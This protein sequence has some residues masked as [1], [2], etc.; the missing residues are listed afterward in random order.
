M[1]EIRTHSPIWGFEIENGELQLGGMPLTRLAARAGMTP[2]FAYDRDLM[3]ARVKELR[4]ALGDQIRIQYAM[5][6]NPMPAV[7]NHFAG[8]VDGI[9][10]ASAGEMAIA[11]DSSMPS[12]K[13]SFA[14]PGKTED[15]IR[16]AVAAGVI[17]NLESFNEMEIAAKKGDGL[18]LVPKV[19]VRVNPDFELKSSGMKMGGG[20]QP[21]GVDA[22]SV[23]D[24]LKRM[25][26]LPL[27]FVGFHIFSGSQNLSVSSLFEAQEKTVELASR[28][29][30]FA[31]SPVL[32]LNMGGG[33]GIPY[34]AGEEPLDLDAVGSNLISLLPKIREAMPKAEVVIELGRYLVGETGI[35]VTRVVDRKVSRGKIY[36]ITDG[37]LNHHLAASGNFGQLIR[38]NYPV[39]LGNRME[40]L[41]VE[42]VNV[43]GCLCTPLDK[44]GDKVS[45][46][47]A[48][49]GDLVV[50]FQS[51]AYGRSASP[52][53]F[54]GHPPPAEL[55]V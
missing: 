33:F 40:Q 3:T 39:A 49:V 17:L 22:E 42:E 36:L 9:D 2:F 19:A 41:E 30:K 45:L 55:L 31:P 8:L 18:G 37:G 54:L 52:T 21:F 7:V 32:K 6:A 51:G 16:R 43:V 29:S 48:Q 14:G 35:Y 34:F 44:L 4:S 50:I 12:S 1:S 10:V 11:L 15:E 28:L 24:M 46:P 38:R 20:A 26:E 53:G 5:K 47:K 13:I 25:S 27:E 23:P